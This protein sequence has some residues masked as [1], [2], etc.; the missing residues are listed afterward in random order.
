MPRPVTIDDI[1]YYHKRPTPV[2]RVETNQL[3]RHPEVAAALMAAIKRVQLDPDL[4]FD[5][6]TG[7]CARPLTPEEL[8]DA[9]EGRQKAWD[10]EQAQYDAYMHDPASVVDTWRI[11]NARRF[12]QAEGL[13]FTEPEEES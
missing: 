10:N 6:D 12:A 13:P 3:T 8:Q 4:E 11:N 2:F 7:E 9:L 5:P 1:E